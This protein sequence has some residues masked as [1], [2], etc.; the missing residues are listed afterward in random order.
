MA[1]G[2]VNDLCGPLN[3]NL[4]EIMPTNRFISF[5]CDVLDGS[6]N[7]SSGS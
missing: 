2:S 3:R 6:N 7:R 1:D 5:F 4:C